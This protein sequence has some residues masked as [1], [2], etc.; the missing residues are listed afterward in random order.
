MDLTR[1]PSRSILSCT[2]CR[3]KKLRCDRLRPCHSCVKR[4]LQCAY[5]SPT[6]APRSGSGRSTKQ[7]Q[8]RIRQLEELVN[9]QRG[10][11]DNIFKLDVEGESRHENPSDVIASS[12]GRIHVG[13]TGM[14]YVSGA[15]WAA[16]QESIADLKDCLE[17]DYSVS[18]SFQEFP[19]PA[20]LMGLCPPGDKGEILDIIPARY[21][22][23]RLVSRF[24]NSMEPGVIVLH[25]PT[26]QAEYNHF[27]EGSQDVSLTW[28]SLLFSIMSLAIFINYRS[29]GEPADPIPNPEEMADEFRRQAAYCLIKD[30]YTKPS[31]YTIEAL[32]L[33]GQTEYFR[34]PD[35]QHELWVLF[36]VV[37]RLAMRVGLHRDG[38]RYAGIS[39]FEAEMRRR[40]WAL[41]SQLESLFSFQMGL[42][43]MIHKGLSD[44]K[45]PRNLLDDDFNEN[46]TTLPP[47]RPDTDF[48]PISYLIA[49]GRIADVFGLITDNVNST[50][51][52]SYQYT[53]RLDQQ[54]NEAYAA[55][56]SNLQFRG[57]GQSVTEPPMIII[58]RYNLDI[59]Y[60]KARCVLHRNY[61]HDGRSDPRYVN[62]RLICIDSAIKLLRH[63]ATIDAQV[64]P[65]GLLYSGRWYLS[66]LTTHNFVLAAMILCLEL[67][68]ISQGSDRTVGENLYSKDE[69]LSTLKTSR[70][71]WSKYKETS[72][73][74]LQAWRSITIML[75]KLG[76]SAGTTTP[77]TDSHDTLSEN[78]PIAG[79]ESL[80]TSPETGARSS[81]YD[82]TF[83]NHV[84]FEHS[85]A[86]MMCAPEDSMI[87]NNL[88]DFS[89]AMDWAQWDATMQNFDMTGSTA[90]LYE[91]Q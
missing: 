33:Y 61:L 67:H 1:A 28:L 49:K 62:S 65:G 22:T 7:L 41:M 27:W 44:T 86:S 5:V 3:Q 8:Q 18:Q 47:C 59:L 26:F 42:P 54:L 19:G 72:A 15:H 32:L 53:L 84:E 91:N 12:F 56:P 25:A 2:F 85:M 14:S 76:S 77:A 88:W 6:S 21:I 79:A 78:E 80:F 50:L 9:V 83:V 30:K 34:S 63:H 68:F 20:L 74:A 13:E 71:V 38:S 40:I 64:Q 37:M 36:G 66:S 90:G 69:L 4:G 60:Q 39:C 73:E 45:L 17:S 16:L 43:R 29:E 35:A 75:G 52:G 10:G 11:E 87:N 57:V 24:F 46:S 70:K 48:T 55:A 31:K 58:G 81:L 89:N 82:S 23:D 51:P